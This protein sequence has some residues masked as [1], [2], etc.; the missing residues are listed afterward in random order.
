M[1]ALENREMLESE[2]VVSS[3]QLS[4]IARGRSQVYAVLADALNQMPSVERLRMLRGAEPLWSAVR[5]D[6]TGDAATAALREVLSQMP[7]E[8]FEEVSAP[9]ELVTELAVERTRL[10]RGVRPG[11][12]LPPAC[13]SVYRHEV[14]TG[15]ESQ[16][17][18][19]AWAHMLA[20][21]RR[22]GFSTPK[23]LQPDYIRRGG[24]FS[25]LTEP[26]R[27]SRVDT[28]RFLSRAGR[29]WSGGGLSG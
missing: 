8:G 19:R 13:E 9:P 11:Y 5:G 18:G 21:Y 17:P 14:Q 28:R 29:G 10:L 7:A 1:N 6:P 4:E 15:F 22:S 12:G 2:P 24:E 27:G 25:G 20:E 26:S 23:G 16:E 3:P